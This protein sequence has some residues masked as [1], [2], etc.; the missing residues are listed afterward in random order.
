MNKL[1]KFNYKIY[2]RI[3]YQIVDVIVRNHNVLRNIVNASMQVY[4]V[5]ISVNVNS[6]RIYKPTSQITLSITI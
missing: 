1:I 6:A 4:S 3:K 5:I 2:V